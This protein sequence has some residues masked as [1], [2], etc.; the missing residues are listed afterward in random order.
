MTI[1]ELTEELMKLYEA[2]NDPDY[3]Q[4]IIQ[5]MAKD[6]EEDLETKIEG[7]GMVIKQLDADAAVIEEEA[8]RLTD[9]A[10]SLKNN[11]KRMKET[12]QQVMIV[13][14]KT[15]IKTNLFTFNVQ[16]NPAS[17]VLD[18][19]DIPLEYLVPQDPTVNKKLIM[20]QLKAGEVLEFAH[21][22]QGQSLRIR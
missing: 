6:V 16:N 18:T 1:Y 19:E 14:G 17:V 4:D 9:R 22:E 8:K 10:K 15:K 20:E 2:A 13:T 7:Y 11:A 5:D 12:L 21:L 3:D